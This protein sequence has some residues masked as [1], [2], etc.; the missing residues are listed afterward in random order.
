MERRLHCARH[1]RVRYALFLVAAFAALSFGCHKRHRS[2][3][4]VRDAEA[5]T[6]K[7]DELAAAAALAGGDG[8]GPVGMKQNGSGNG[9]NRWRDTAVYVDGTPVGVVAFGE[10][11]IALKPTWVPEEHSVEFDYGYKGPRTRTTYE[12]RYRMIEYLTALGVDVAHIKEIQVMGPKSTSVI[13]ASG[14]ELR[15]KKGQGFM[16]RFGGVVGGKPIPVVPPDFGNGA[17]PDKMGAV[18]VYIHRKPPV[19]DPDEGLMLDG[20]P[21]EGI[22]YYGDALKAG[23]RVYVDDRLSTIIGQQA[24]EETASVTAPDGQKR[25]KLEPLLKQLG[26][27]LSK[28]KEAW[29]IADERRQ[30]KFT[31]AELDALTFAVDPHQKHLFLVGDAKVRASAIALHSHELRPSELPQI[32]P[33]ET[34]N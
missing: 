33:D 26:V 10:L 31:R 27:D 32:R 1:M 20:K 2:S 8:D 22:P 6:G 34:N 12:R 17:M 16:F 7:K 24:L 29:A 4:L 21:V 15:S 30:Q 25:W 14:K 9:L 5:S 23:V 3:V 11:P 28:V 13:V 18:M 19:L